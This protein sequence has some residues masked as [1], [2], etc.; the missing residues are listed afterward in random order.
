MTC[1]YE[2]IVTSLIEEGYYKPKY[3][4]LTIRLISMKIEE[5][6]QIINKFLLKKMNKELFFSSQKTKIQKRFI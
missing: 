6:I 3:Q 1:S 5:N 4:V 2:A